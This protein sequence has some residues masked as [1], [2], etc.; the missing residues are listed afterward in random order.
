VSVGAA[1]ARASHAVMLSWGWRRAAIAWLAGALSVL[2]LAP[3]NAWPI[4]FFTFPVAVWLIDGAS[5]GRLGGVMSAAVA[6]W[7]FGFGYFVAGLYWTGFAMLVD[8]KTFAWL[9]PFAVLGLPAG[10]AFFFALAFA[11]ARMMWTNGPMRILALAVALTAAEWLRGH[12]LTGFPWNTIGYALTGPLILAQAS[13]LVGL[14]GLTFF[15][16]YLFAAPAVLTDDRRETRR[17]RPARR[18]GGL[19]D[20]PAAAH[21]DRTGRWREAAHHAAEPAAG[22]Q[23]QLQRP[24]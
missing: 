6:G 12:I 17:P 21:A 9:L 18:L 2:A 11:V 23:V 22:Y 4:L 24:P 15:A 1:L 13:S 8:A 3:I 14:W 16:S 5:A 7:W 20:A 19:R 10:L